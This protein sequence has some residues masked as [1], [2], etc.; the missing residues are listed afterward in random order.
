MGSCDVDLG[1]AEAA[2]GGLAR[3]FLSVADTNTEEPVGS[4][5]VDCAAAAFGDVVCTGALLA[6]EADDTGWEEDEEEWTAFFCEQL[7]EPE[8]D[9]G[10]VGAPAVGCI[11]AAERGGGDSEGDGDGE[12]REASAAV[13][14]RLG[15]GRR[16]GA[17]GGLG[18]LS[19]SRPR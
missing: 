11:A 8:E 2:C 17:A 9:E 19:P 10:L 15:I 12:G 4:L 14:W 13:E 7:V 5:W 16:K 3:H 6:V 18:F 1:K